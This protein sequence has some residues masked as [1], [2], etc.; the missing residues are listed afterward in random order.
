MGG[1]VLDG[2]GRRDAHDGGKDALLVEPDAIRAARVLG[3]CG[4]GLMAVALSLLA[5]L[6][7]V[8]GGAAVGCFC[9]GKP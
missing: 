6:C 7:V 2:Q 5:V 3:C 4:M 1:S 8:V 9:A